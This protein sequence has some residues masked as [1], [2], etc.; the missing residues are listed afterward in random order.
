M[1]AVFIFLLVLGGVLVFPI[2]VFVRL[3]KLRD[4]VKQL[5]SDVDRLRLITS[6]A[7]GAAP[8]VAATPDAEPESLPPPAWAQP[9]GGLFGAP[10]PAEPLAAPMPAAPM[11]AAPM[12]AAPMPA[13]PIAPLTPTEPEPVRG[14]FP[15]PPG[16]RPAR[17]GERLIYR[18]TPAAGAPS[19]AVLAS[20]AAAPPP[21]E[22]PARA[23]FD[24]AKLEQL[25]GGVWL[26]NLGSVVLLIGVFL[27][28]VWGYTTH[29]F[30]PQVLVI[31][32]VALGLAL[33]W[34]GD[35]VARK[36]PPFGHALIGVGIGIVY[37]T[38]YLGYIRLH[39]LGPISALALLVVVS[40]GAIVAGL[41]YRVQA[42]AAFGVI[43]AFLPQF[44]AR[45]LGMP[46]FEIS[47]A[48]LLGYL[49]AIDL[50]VFA[51]AARAGWSR[52]D[53]VAIVLSTL[54]WLTAFQTPAWGWGVQAGLAGL[55]TVLGVAPLPRLVR[56]EGRVR[57]IDLAVVAAA[58]LALMLA[59]TPF[60]SWA[61]RGQVSMMFFAL[62]A[63]MLGAAL[64]VDSRRPERDLWVPLTAAATLYLA[65]GLERAIG[66]VY[67]SLAWAAE[68]VV[69][70]V[71]GLRAR[72]GWLRAMG[73]V[74]LLI[75]AVLLLARLDAGGWSRDQWPVFYGGALRDLACIVALLVAA[76]LLARGQAQ[77]SSF[78]DS[79]PD[80]WTLVGH[81]LLAYWLSNQA[82]HMAAALTESGGLFHAPPPPVGIGVGARRAALAAGLGAVAWLVQATVLSWRGPRASVVR[83]LCS[84]G[85][86]M[87]A[88]FALCLRTDGGW[89]TDQLPYLNPA[90][91]LD[92]LAAALMAVLALR[93]AAD[94]EQ[95]SG[96]EHRF[97]EVWVT[98]ASVVLMLYGWREARHMAIVLLR[99]DWV[100][101][102]SVPPD[103]TGREFALASAL[104][105]VAWF[106][107]G[108]VLLLI[109]LRP[110]AGWLRVL[111]HVALFAACLALMGGFGAPGWTR[112]QWPVF[113]T[114]ALRDLLC[115]V[116]LFVVA[117]SLARVRGR[118]KA[119][120][121]HAPELWA[122]AGHLFLVF[123]LWHQARDLAAALTEP[124]SRFAALPPPAGI[125]V[126][127]RRDA[128][129][130]AMATT[131]WFAQ[132]ALISW[133]PARTAGALRLFAAGLAVVALFMV[134]VR[135]GAGWW[136]DLPPFL[137]PV[138]LL[139][140]TGVAILV[141]VALR[142]ATGRAGLPAHERR[143]P[144]AWA[145]A[146]SL[147]LM[148]WSV[149]ETRH[150]AQ[151]LVR[152]GALVGV[153]VDP[154]LFRREHALG[155]AFAS[156]AW[157][158]QA[159]IVLLVGWGR[160]SAF[161]RWSGLVLL[162]LTLFKFLAFDLQTVD[163]F[164]RFLT[165]I[166]V[167]AAMLAFSYAYQRRTKA[168]KPEGP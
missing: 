93:H 68:G 46:G 15:P 25:V 116:A 82:N 71:L 21:P 144:E 24:A 155:A 85:L 112:Q 123:W 110:R 65:A 160:E 103:A 156:V 157:L 100:A 23:A 78:E 43:G 12:P 84:A 4:R 121:R 113:H 125:V 139:D 74:V 133:R 30:G 67:T 167:G 17:P 20:A 9:S 158:V 106:A 105:A 16:P 94:R 18:S 73:H 45:W 153:S 39:V 86:G 34:R 91:L 109:G 135:P 117:G 129:A 122:L 164:W 60:L 31:S 168:A 96:P 70:L 152:P 63:I 10:R 26:Q 28:I 119:V 146:A 36:T 8:M 104:A 92:L 44:M 38:L 142:S 149:R 66:P 114:A 51:L 40:F 75:S 79:A 83:R 64:W 151:A 22:Q 95:H 32:G 127:L 98:G 77:L 2:I 134:L 11:P 128:L 154:E 58:P 99:P 14:Q 159:V 89:W 120:E 124:G 1:E 90:A 126:A 145:T 111:G 150:L 47:P 62:A 118:L 97:A 148:L 115:I 102:M 54:T 69:L 3:G 143:T 41:R 29:R 35:R 57:P 87:L 7:P 161:L 48:F 80:A 138:S 88:L 50:L 49:S 101:G 108:V 165:A 59:S 61:D 81:V 19:S 76:R 52:L 55:F 132:A 33:A 163:V 72:G 141:L 27:M 137:S 56:V 131:A 53:L 147:L 37:L 107:Q 5:E 13:A 136:T 6:R 130:L 42:I 140:V 166:A 162:G